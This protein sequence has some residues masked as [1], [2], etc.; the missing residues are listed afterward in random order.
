MVPADSVR[1][2]GRTADAVADGQRIRRRQSLFDGIDGGAERL[3][4]QI[5][6]L[7][8]VQCRNVDAGGGNHFRLVDRDIGDREAL[9]DLP[10]ARH[11]ARGPRL[12]VVRPRGY[13][14]FVVKNLAEH[15]AI[16]NTAQK[17]GHCRGIVESSRRK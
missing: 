7:S 13:G 8:F 2:H 1:G 10:V 14:L 9:D 3:R 16:W 6:E 11:E 15:F 17:L 4:D 12:I 5:P